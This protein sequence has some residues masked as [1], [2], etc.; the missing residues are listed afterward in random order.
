MGTVLDVLVEASRH[1]ASL[2]QPFM[3]DASAR[4]LDQLA[5]PEDARAFA[6][7]GP[8]HA[9]KAGTKLPKP[10]GVFPR[11]ENGEKTEEG[12]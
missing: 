7:L 12:E 3:P 10:E 8:D 11:Y 9:L 6:C 5:V 2:P 4:L 1:L